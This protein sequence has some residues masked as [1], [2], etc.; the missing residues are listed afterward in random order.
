M[1]SG[2]EKNRTD[3]KSTLEL[4]KRLQETIAKAS[5][6]IDSLLES[7]ESSEARAQETGSGEVNGWAGLVSTSS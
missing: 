4:L 6:K 1:A 7:I 2:E 5:N 3:S